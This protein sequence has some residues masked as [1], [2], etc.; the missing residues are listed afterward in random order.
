MLDEIKVETEGLVEELVRTIP[1]I[2]EDA[3]Q[4]LPAITIKG[5]YLKRETFRKIV[6]PFMNKKE[7]SESDEAR[8]RASIVEACWRDWSG[9]TL[10]NMAR[11]SEFVLLNYDA[12]KGAF[13]EK[14]IG[15]DEELPWDI[16]DAKWLAVR[17]D[18]LRFQPVTEELGKMEEYAIVREQNKKK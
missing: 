8:F 18:A 7:T 10:R 6:K 4:N 11:V 5:T 15:E 17:M 14:G 13:T 1:L 3:G 2:E 9:V 16:K 12:L